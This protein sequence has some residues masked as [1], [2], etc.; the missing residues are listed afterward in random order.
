MNASS[1]AAVLPASR[2]WYPLM[3]T[4][5]QRG[6]SA[7]VKEMT[8]RTR[9]IDCRGGNT[10]SFCAWYSFR[11]SFCSVPPIARRGMPVSSACATN[12]A[13]TGAA[14]ELIVMDVVVV[15]RSIPEKRSRMSASVSIATPQ[16]PT[17]PSDI[18]SSL[19]RPSS[20]GMS[21]AVESPSPPARMISLKRTFVSSAVPN[22]ANIRIVHSL[23]RYMEAYGPRV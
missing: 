4:L 15:P 6:I 23:L 1:S 20:V 17:S 2:M 11:M 18:G 8:S 16:R 14:G 3:D 19:S 5:C 13:S 12:M 10:N 9:R 22:P 7:A 21:N